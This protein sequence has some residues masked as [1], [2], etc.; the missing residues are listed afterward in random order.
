MQNKNALFRLPTKINIF[1]TWLIVLQYILRN[2]T[3][4]FV[5]RHFLFSYSLATLF[6]LEDICCKYNGKDLH[7]TRYQL[8]KNIFN[9]I[10]SYS[11]CR[12]RWETQEY[13]LIYFKPFILYPFTRWTETTILFN[14]Y[15]NYFNYLVQSNLLLWVEIN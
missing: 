4:T 3:T 10:R 9:E 6:Q 8:H 1:L 12:I 15:A 13:T 11:V 7:L 14:G 5:T 2:H